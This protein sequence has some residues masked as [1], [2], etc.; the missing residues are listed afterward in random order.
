MAHWKKFFDKEYVGSWDLEDGDR[1]VTISKVEAGELHNQSTNTKEKKPVLSFEGR[2]KKLVMN[3]TNC[4]TVARLYGNDTDDWVGKDITLFRSQC[5]V[6]GETDD[7]V[8][9]R[10]DAPKALKVAK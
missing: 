2:S 6:G 3:N 10:P 1:T 5:E 8:R 9:V 7:C 4:K